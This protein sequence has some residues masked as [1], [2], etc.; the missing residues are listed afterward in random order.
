MEK[1]KRKLIIDT[2]P[3]GDDALALLLLAKYKELFDIRLVVS[4][5]GNTPL[6][7]TTKNV[8][9][10]VGKF[11]NGASVARGI[12]HTIDA[13][14]HFVTAQDVFGE[15]GLGH[16]V[17][18][19]VEY[20]VIDD[21]IEAMR[22]EIMNSSTPVTIVTLGPVSN[23][24][25]LFIKYPEVKDNIEEI[26][27]MIASI[28][29]D[30][31][32][33]P[34]AEFNAYCDVSALD[35]LINSGIRIIFNTINLGKTTV[36]KKVDFLC[37]KEETSYSKMVKDIVFGISEF[38]DPNIAYLFDVN[39]IMA[40]VRPELYEFVP[41]DVSLSLDKANSGEVKMVRNNNATSCYLVA[42]DPDFV[43]KEIVKE[44][45]GFN[46]KF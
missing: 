34:Y 11:L 36:V 40:L 26:H 14:P 12:G 2:D 7:L 17:V 15:S 4:T 44:I 16:F 28:N 5:S 39:T 43:K 38:G 42:R 9:F 31:N 32:V 30:G 25:K 22:E 18:P 13:D 27:S 33:K 35:V 29:G 45:V 20:P 1:N 46:P 24:A 37:F 8:K 21:C 6:N 41:C 3:G 19:D 23:I 10:L